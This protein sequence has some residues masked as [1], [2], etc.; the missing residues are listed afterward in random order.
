MKS[1]DMPLLLLTNKRNDCLA[2]IKDHEE[3]IISY[4]KNIKEH[5]K[6]VRNRNS[7]IIQKRREIRELDKA[8]DKLGGRRRK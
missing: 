5:E 7:D 8:I 2:I 3:S 4:K 1:K 6:F